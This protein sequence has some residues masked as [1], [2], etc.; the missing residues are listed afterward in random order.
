MSKS[1][2]EY[3]SQA[4]KQG[5]LFPK[6]I[7]YALEKINLS[8]E[9]IR[10]LQLRKYFYEKLKNKYFS[11]VDETVYTFKTFEEKKVIWIFWDSGIENAPNIVKQCYNSIQKFK[12]KDYEVILLNR[13]NMF[14]YVTFPD[15]IIK[16][17]NN[18]TIPIAN[19]SDI[20]RLFLLVQ[21]GGIW[22]DATVYLS[23]NIDDIASIDG[24]FVFSNEY[25]NDEVINFDNWFIKAQPNNLLL[26]KTLNLM[27]MY[28]QDEDVLHEY[29]ICH[30]FFKMVTEKYPDEWEKT[31]KQTTMLPHSLYRMQYERFNA[32]KLKKDFELCSIHKMSYKNLRLDTKD[33]YISKIM[34]GITYEDLCK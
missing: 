19:F 16:K 17:V 20:L 25:R 11:K 22:M 9:T 23:S 24:M 7:C 8:S 10:R 14:D 30:L 3:F 18:G 28:W 13:E 12:P 32:Q 2:K 29:F 21:Y 31:Y 34:D 27:L 33:T 1:Y 4:L 15:Y 26:R 5:N 6:I